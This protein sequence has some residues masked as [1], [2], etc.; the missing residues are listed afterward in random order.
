[1]INFQLVEEVINNTLMN[2]EE[3]LL[4]QLLNWRLRQ[5]LFFL[6]QVLLDAV[7]STNAEDRI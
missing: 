2:E 3:G 1:V 6:D 4:M 5:G 7:K